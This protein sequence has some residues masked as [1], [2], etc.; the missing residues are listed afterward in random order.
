MKKQLF[1]VFIV[2]LM[3]IV[4]GFVG[5]KNETHIENKSNTENQNPEEHKEEQNIVCADSF[6]WGTWVRMDSG[7]EYEV[8]ESSIK[9]GISSYKVTASDEST[10]TV[11]GLGVFKKESDSVIVCENIPYFRKGGTNLEYSLK[12][13]GFTQSASSSSAI[14]NSSSQLARA[15][16]TSVGGIKGKGKSTKYKNFESESESDTDGTITFTAPTANDPQTVEIIAGDEIVV[17]PGLTIANSGDYMGTVA[18]VGKNDYNLKI[19]G[20]ISD[21]QKN[22]GYLY[23]N[24]AKTYN[25]VLTIT[26]I[27]E[28]KCKSSVCSIT[29]ADP[30]LSLTSTKNLEGFTVSTLV[31]GAT[32]TVEL[33]LL[34][35][36]LSEPYI[37]TGL[38]V[39]LTNSTGQEWNDYIPLRFFKGTIPI[40]ISAKNPENNTNAALNG[41]VIYPDGNNQFFAIDHNAC[42]PIFVPTFGSDKP[43]KLVFSGATV[44][45]KLDDSTEMYYTVEAGSVKP[46]DVVTS[47]SQGTTK[48][49]LNSYM[50]FGGENH[51]EQ[52]AFSVT[53][54]FEAYLSEG[55]IDYYTISADGEDYYGPGGSDF[56]S[57]SYMNEKGDAPKSFLVA[58]GAVL[59]SIQLPELKCDGYD[60]LGWYSGTKKV[61]AGAYTVKEDVKLVAKWR[62]TSYTIEYYLN[63]GKNN[64]ANPSSYTIETSL[65]TLQKPS[66][67]GYDFEGWFDT[68]DFEENEVT[69]I[70]GGL[71]ADI[72]LYAKWKIVEYKIN[73]ELNGG[74]NAIG[75][76]EKYT[77]E[78]DELKLLEP[79]KEGYLFGGWFTDSE[80][81]GTEKY[82]IDKGSWGDKTYY[83]KWKKK[84]TI[85][86]VTEH[87]ETPEAIVMGEGDILTEVQLPELKEKGWKNYGWYIDLEFK[88][89]LKVLIGYEITSSLTLYAKWEKW[90]GPDDGFIFVQ[91]TTVIGSDEYYPR[92]K[93]GRNYIGAFPSGKTVTINDF[94]IC[95]HEV[96]QKEYMNIMHTNKSVFNDYPSN[97]E[98]QENRPAENISWEEAVYFCNR[99]SEKNGLTP[100]YTVNGSNDVIKWKYKYIQEKYYDYYQTFKHID[101]IVDCDWEA[102]G[103]RLPTEAEWEY[104]ARGG[105]KN[106]GTDYFS[107]YY[108]GATTSDYYAASDNSLD[109]IGWYVYNSSKRTHEVKKKQPNVLGLF[110]MSGNVKEW[111]WD[112]S[113]L[114]N[115]INASSDSFRITRGGA[116]SSG[117]GDTS[118]F[119]RLEHFSYKGNCDIGF[120][121]VRSAQ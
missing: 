110:D 55:E 11:E 104:A 44:T 36:E 91:G 97:G 59:S 118:V 93:E 19:T 74:S 61:I 80:F 92:R 69:E 56:Y 114:S 120:R 86:Y 6:F 85:T 45:S 2:S 47:V 107:F 98:V 39:T 121:L 99:Y 42:K 7:S 38:I 20:K 64:A 8:L 23:G 58:G 35:G 62:L 31:G 63:G 1:S 84:C 76:P 66:R 46:R 54:G 43:F 30:K 40:T 116:Y 3:M 22:G 51:S 52:T 37:D 106:Y 33:S 10:L 32:M 108:A 112:L 28:N 77:I 9:Q 101:G 109:N 95:D 60:F 78:M 14:L 82:I 67:T 71:V 72:V 90:I 73:Y 96:T 75:N 29:A 57:V 79:E 89:N 21:E 41:F 68:A 53:E 87:G 94:Y 70:A 48:E 102:D 34:Y 24:N 111:C 113:N 50:I 12:L 88:E 117:A 16:G 83:A 25:M 105:L 18:L 103:Y 100:C 81:S 115:Y 4:I 27:S 5:C 119:F 15:A 26:N 49:E 17:I 13:V 65:I